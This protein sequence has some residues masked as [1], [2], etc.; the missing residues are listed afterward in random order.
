M[1][2]NAP[3]RRTID[4]SRTEAIPFSRLVKV[5]W[6]KMLDTRGGFW[7]LAITGVLLVFAVAIVLLVIGLDDGVRVGAFDWSTILTIPLSLLLPVFAIQSVTSEWSQRTGLVT[8]SLEPH[9]IRVLLAKVSAVI[10]LVLSTIVVAIA[11]GA[12]ANV[13]GAQIGGYDARWNLEV[14]TLAATVF[15]QLVYFLM[16]F[17]IGMVLLSTPAAIAIFYVVALLLPFMVYGTLY[18]LFDWAQ[19]FIPWIDLQFATAPLLD[20]NDSVSTTNVAQMVVACT[21]WVVVPLVLGSR[22]VLSS[23]PK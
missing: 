17:G 15:V 21:I 19:D 7:L 4:I 13:V 8:F 6:R 12:V 20:P 11:L 14:S 16:A 10:L 22:R 2:T 23:E 5:E 3:E 18:A 9:R 1:T